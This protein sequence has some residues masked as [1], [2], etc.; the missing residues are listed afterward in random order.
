MLFDLCVSANVV[1]NQFSRSSPNESMNSRRKN[2]Q[3][4]FSSVDGLLTTYSSQIQFQQFNYGRGR[5][6]GRGY[7]NNKTQC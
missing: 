4:S 1:V 6:C 5:G 3:V 2:Y 7:G